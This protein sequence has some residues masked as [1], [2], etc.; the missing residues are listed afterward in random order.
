MSAPRNN[1]ISLTLAWR[2]REPM[3]GHATIHAASL[4][5]WE[6]ETLVEYAGHKFGRVNLR[7]KIRDRAYP[8]MTANYGAYAATKD[9]ALLLAMTRQEKLAIQRAAHKAGVESVAHWCRQV[10]LWASGAAQWTPPDMRETEDLRTR[11]KPAGRAL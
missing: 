9:V 4:P 10:L 7:P 3:R 5:P 8:S 6:R 2:D 11:S 1:T